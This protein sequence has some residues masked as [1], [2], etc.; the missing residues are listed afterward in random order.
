MVDANIHCVIDCGSGFTKAGYSGEEAPRHIFPTIVGRTKVEGVY[1]GN[2]KKE[3]IIG[4]EASKKFGILDITY[5]IQEGLVTKWE[6][7]E[8]IWHYTFYTQLKVPPEEYNVLLTEAPF[9]PRENREKTI[10]LLFE[11]FNVPCAFL[12]SQS[13]LSAYAAGKSTG[14]IIDCGEGST[15]FV[16]IYEGFICRNTVTNI[17]IAG[18]AIHKCLVDLLI[19]KGNGEVLKS[20]MQREAIKKAKNELCFVSQ[21]LE[22]ESDKRELEFHLPDQRV[23]KI[24]KEKYEAPEVLFNPSMFGYEC[25]SLQDQFFETLGKVD[26]DLHDIM[27]GNIICNG[28]TTLFRGFKERA[29]REIKEITKDYDFKKKVHCYPEAQFLAWIGGSI[30]TSLGNFEKLWITQ[31]EYKEFGPK[32]VHQ[33][34]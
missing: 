18:K 26:R 30:L 12:C 4:K 7:A 34:C 21:D 17:P 2:E 10:Q 23:I 22:K 14:L 15:N 20:K 31:A 1:V 16:P 29:T 28:G 33:K 11:K 9:N 13:V 19:K 5:P 27:L 3:S 6:E 24:G 32:I 25:K 8:K